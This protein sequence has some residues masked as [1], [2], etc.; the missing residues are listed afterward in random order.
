MQP[1]HC[2]LHLQELMLTFLCRF[3]NFIVK[4]E[5]GHR[6]VARIANLLR[7]LISCWNL[8]NKYSVKMPK[9]RNST[10]PL[11]SIWYNCRMMLL[12]F[13]FEMQSMPPFFV[14]V[15]HNRHVSMKLNI[16]VSLFEVRSHS[17][18]R[19]V[20][21]FFSALFPLLHC[22]ISSRRWMVEQSHGIQSNGWRLHRAGWKSPR[23][24]N[25]IIGQCVQYTI[26]MN[27]LKLF[28]FS[29]CLKKT[30][31][32]VWCEHRP[33]ARIL[34]HS[35]ELNTKTSELTVPKKMWHIHVNRTV[36]VDN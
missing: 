28:F 20:G 18:F 17:S 4:I 19:W 1:Y 11:T 5:F 7:Q 36:N 12:S 32:C 25:K 33:N 6:F 22:G 15:V 13:S 8:Q 34:P 14:S 16:L 27:S 21:N 29:R 3:D 24:S 26:S 2:E 35:S 10:M 9:N 23:W 31:A 30:D